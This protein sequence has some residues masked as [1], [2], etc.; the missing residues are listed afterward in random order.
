MTACFFDMLFNTCHFDDGIRRVHTV[1]RET[2]LG[3]IGVLVEPK[4]SPKDIKR[5]TKDDQ[6]AAKKR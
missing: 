5:E 4:R 3:T 1:T 2:D 6:N